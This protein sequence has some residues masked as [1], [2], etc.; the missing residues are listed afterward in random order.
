M[1]RSDRRSPNGSLGS[2]VALADRR[3]G[4]EGEI[5]MLLLRN[6]QPVGF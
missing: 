3:V 4:D 1:L 6:K 5:F 2:N